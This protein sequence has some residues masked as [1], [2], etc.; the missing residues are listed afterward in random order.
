MK[1]ETLNKAKELKED[2][3]NIALV[4]SDSANHRWIRVITDRF[5]RKSVIGA[6]H[7]D[8][9]Y[10]VRFQRELAEWLKAK[11]EQYQKELDEL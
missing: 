7:T 8:L 10:S 5:K 1:I 3:D 6:Y 4:L 11:L 9:F 2:I